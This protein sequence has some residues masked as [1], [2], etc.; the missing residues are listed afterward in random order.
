MFMWADF[1][2]VVW[3]PFE[4]VRRMPGAFAAAFTIYGG[5]HHGT[6]PKL[7]KTSWRVFHG[8]ADVVVDYQ[9][10]QRMVDALKKVGADVKFTIY[11]GVN[12]NS[13]ENA[14]AEPDLLPWLFSKSE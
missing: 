6:A 10:S 13:W 2:W 8:D 14:F 11:E 12:H 7:T 4:I 9:H 5:A 1:Q 3:A